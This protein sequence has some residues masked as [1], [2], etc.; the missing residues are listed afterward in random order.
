MTGMHPTLETIIAQIALLS[1]YIVGMSYTLIIKPRRERA[2]LL[3]RRSR[4][5]IED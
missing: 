1:V 2:I 3:A 5:E 4:K